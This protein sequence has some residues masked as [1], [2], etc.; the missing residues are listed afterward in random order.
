VALWPEGKDGLSGI[1]VNDPSPGSATGGRARSKACLSTCATS[2]AAP[3]AT[4][5]A[6]KVSGRRRR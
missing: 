1:E 3:V 4:A 5:A 2:E 6:R